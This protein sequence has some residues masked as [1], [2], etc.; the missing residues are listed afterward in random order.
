MLLLLIKEDQSKSMQSAYSES[1]ELQIHSL[2]GSTCSLWHQQ[3][4]TAKYVQ[5]LHVHGTQVWSLLQFLE[6]HQE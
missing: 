1:M 4:S 2:Q 6:S 5:A 3:H